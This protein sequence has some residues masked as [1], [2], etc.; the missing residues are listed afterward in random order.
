MGC[1]DKSTG[2]NLV[3]V[4]TRK[5]SQAAALAVGVLS[6]SFMAS[7]VAGLRRSEYLG[8]AAEGLVKLCSHYLRHVHALSRRDRM[9]PG[10]GARPGSFGGGSSMQHKQLLAMSRVVAA[11]AVALFILRDVSQRPPPAPCTADGAPEQADLDGDVGGA[12]SS[13][14]EEEE[15]AAGARSRSDDA[16]GYFSNVEVQV[17][18]HVLR[19]LKGQVYVAGGRRLSDSCRSWRVL[20]FLRAVRV[21][22]ASASPAILSRVVDADIVDLLVSLVVQGGNGAEAAVAPAD[23][24]EGREGREGQE[25]RE[26]GYGEEDAEEEQ[27]RD[28]AQEVLLLLTHPRVNARDATATEGT[29]VGAEH[30]GV[31]GGRGVGEGDGEESGAAHMLE[32]ALELCSA[33]QPTRR[34]A[35]LLDALEVSRAVTWE[36]PRGEP[37]RHMDT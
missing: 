6:P 3:L 33:L 25:G 15:Q 4:L 9:S 12:A 1:V 19:A 14:R 35:R 10:A 23:V 28:M 26:E 5:P 17:I 31:T 21:A 20:L 8:A 18:S 27:V 22:L 13:R 16:F 37:L 29:D 11:T 7:P 34:T 32:E 24:G 30:A 36:E 2:T